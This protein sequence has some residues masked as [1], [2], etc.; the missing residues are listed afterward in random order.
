MKTSSHSRSHSRSEE[1]NDCD[2]A[3][4]IEE[5]KS[6]P[7]NIS[8]SG[9]TGVILFDDNVITGS[10][11]PFVNSRLSDSISWGLNLGMYVIQLYMGSQQ[12]FARSSIKDDDIEKTKE[13]LRRYPIHFFTHSPVVFNLAGS[14][15][16]KSLAWCGNARVDNMMESLIQSLSYELSILNKIGGLGTVI[17]PGSCIQEAGKSKE[18]AEEEA[19]SAIAKTLSFVNFASGKAKV[20]L[21]I[22]AGEANKVSYNLDQL[23]RIRQKVSPKNR[24]NIAYCL[25]TCHAF[26]SGLYNLSTLDGVKKMFADI[27]RVKSENLGCVEL[28][29]LNDSRVPFGSRT[30]RHECLRQ[31]YIWSNDDKPLRYLLA[32]A[33]TRRIPCVLET[34]PADMFTLYELIGESM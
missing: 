13:L 5:L 2:C 33:G 28:I 26:A 29:H 16:Q 27:D 11:I 34:S 22:C 14:V 10:H 1:H 12:S 19:I 31:G 21:E 8:Q 15:G 3:R 25:D 4:M 17:H 20:L 6:I 32:E 23:V 7:L 30:D 9:E 18:Q 24:E